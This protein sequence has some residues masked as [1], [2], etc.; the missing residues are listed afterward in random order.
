MTRTPGGGKAMYQ[1]GKKLQEEN[2]A[3]KAQ[4][5]EAVRLLEEI[6]VP[7]HYH[8]DTYQRLDRER[9]AFLAQHADLAA[10]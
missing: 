1:V 9:Q 6:E 5:R 3:L 10:D 8:K 7:T 4:L 2:A